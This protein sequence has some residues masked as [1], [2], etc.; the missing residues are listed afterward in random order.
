MI[1]FIPIVALVLCAILAILSFLSKKKAEMGMVDG[2]LTPCPGAPNCVCSEYQGKFFV[3][4]LHFNEP[5][6]E[7]WERGKQVLQEIGGRIE[8]EEKEAYLRAV[9]ATKFLRFRDDVELRM[10]REK[11]RI[12]IRSSSRIGYFDFGQNRK[13]A[14]E[15][16]GRFMQTQQR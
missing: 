2:R 12:H 15:I 3:E 8:S 5:P 16:R 13:R 7:A 10:D 9:F 6:Q 11:G 14:K 1:H 4:P